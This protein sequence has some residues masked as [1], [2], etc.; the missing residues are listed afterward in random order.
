VY[1]FAAL[2]VLRAKR[3]GEGEA[4]LRIPGGATGITLVTVLGVGSTLLSIVFALSPP[5]HGSV[6]LF[7]AK[8]IS[9]CV[10]FLGI[11]LAFYYARRAAPEAADDASNAS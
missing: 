9:G 1:L 6:S 2:P 3:I 5:E 4:V 10:V 7:Y 8:V 11:G